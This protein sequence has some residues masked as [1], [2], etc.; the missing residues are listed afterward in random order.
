M[1]GRVAIFFLA[2]FLLG[3]CTSESNTSASQSSDFSQT[4]SA[5]MSLPVDVTKGAAL[6]KNQCSSC[7]DDGNSIATKPDFGAQNDID[8]IDR[9]GQFSCEYLSD[10]ASQSS[11]SDYI[12]TAMPWGAV[13]NCDKSCASD[14]AAY[15]INLQQ[16]SVPNLG[17]G[18]DDE[19]GVDNPS[20]LCPLKPGPARNNGCPVPTNAPDPDRG[21]QIAG[22]DVY[23]AQCSTCHGSHGGGTNIGPSLI[24]GECKVCGDFGDL[25]DI[26]EMSMPTPGACI[27]DCAINVATYVQ[28]AFT[29]SIQATN[30][31]AE[32]PSPGIF[33]LRRLNKREYTNTIVD[34]FGVDKSLMNRIP[35]E[36]NSGFDND[37]GVLG[38]NSSLVDSFI[39]ASE[40]V[41]AAFVSTLSATPIVSSG[42]QCNTTSQC[43]TTYGASATDCVDSLSN[44]SYCQCGTDRCD[45]GASPSPSTSNR[46]LSCAALNDQCA[47]DFIKN[48]G[49]KIYRRPLSTQENK[50]LR[51][52]YTEGKSI[53]FAAGI[54]LVV[55]AML[56]SPSF[57]YR[58]EFG[59]GSLSSGVTP[60]TSWEIATR[61][62]YMFWATTPD[63]KL[64]KLAAE[65][66][67]R[68]K[69]VIAEQAQRLLSDNKAKKVLRLFFRNLIQQT[70][71]LAA[72]AD[73]AIYPHMTAQAPQLYLKELDAFVDHI[74]W[75]KEASWDE[76][77]SADYTFVNNAL[78]E[79]YG[80][81]PPGSDDF[82][83][84]SEQGRHFGL[85][86]L[87]AVVASRAHES[88][89]APVL[90]GAFILQSFMCVSIEVPADDSGVEIKPPIPDP[91]ST[92][93]ERW[94]QATKGKD[95]EGCHRTLNPAGFAFENFD[96]TG[97]WREKDKN[98]PVDASVDLPG[99]D[100]SGMYAGP[101]GLVN[102]L[103]ESEQAAQC[104]VQLW[105]QYSYG[106]EM[107]ANTGG[108]DECSMQ[109]AYNT[110]I[111]KNKS[112]KELL[113]ALTQTDAFL[114]RTEVK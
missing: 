114:Y 12:H 94:I 74:L 40:V 7:H 103:V 61:L 69:K 97:R 13:N 86:S 84:V 65:D 51:A 26:I 107:H 43:R 108:A 19:D 8:I 58:A 64:L 29:A 79:V 71:I 113:I 90:R 100:I 9:Y 55:E 24:Q 72:P 92:T 11:L 105:A 42:D 81:T 77:L 95:C 59:T 99:T 15:I 83:Q 41:A 85:F 3:A 60:L 78:A 63:D 52:L 96:P 111:G 82:V 18:D 39:D 47:F 87:G 70:K 89:T 23:T 46:L 67:L 56:Q 48:A 32:A 57:L 66:K 4:S 27:D 98:L 93:R 14:I 49:Q 35:A 17:P 53:D 38:V 50:Q 1:I 109:S 20:D 62:S 5:P 30:C 31:A 54:Q 75:Q 34:L 22:L 91:N 21:D 2:G 37:A 6:Y 102:A 36:Q 33:P 88:E 76:F 44:Q 106:H 73:P 16:T 28:S 25:V 45:A 68:D 101:A 104:A 112:V 80:F 10:C 110:F